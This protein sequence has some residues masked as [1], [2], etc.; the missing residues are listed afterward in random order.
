[1]H[2]GAASTWLKSTTLIFSNALAITD[3]FHSKRFNRFGCT[4][5]LPQLQSA[6]EKKCA[7]SG[8]E[9]VDKAVHSEVV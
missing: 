3:S 1:V 6:E 9:K 4:T 7:D 8:G 2:V 5:S